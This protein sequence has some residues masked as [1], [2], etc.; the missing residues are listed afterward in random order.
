MTSLFSGGKN[1]IISEDADVEAKARMAEVA[2]LMALVEPEPAKQ[3][4]DGGGGGGGGGG[5][6]GGDGE[7][8]FNG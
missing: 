2:K 7:G 3:R 4:V 8:A 6:G 1:D 5:S